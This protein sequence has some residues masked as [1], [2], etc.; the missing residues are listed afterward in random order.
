MARRAATA[1]P[2]R[3]SKEPAELALTIEVQRTPNASS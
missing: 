3:T 2:E 1:T